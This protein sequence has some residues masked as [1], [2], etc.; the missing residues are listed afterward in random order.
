MYS[1]RELGGVHRWGDV[2]VCNGR[3]A[4]VVE[5]TVVSVEQREITVVNVMYIGVERTC[6]TDG[7]GT[8]S[9]KYK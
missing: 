3:Y 9:N 6:S 2:K 8:D 7:D 1:L 5:R 4:Q